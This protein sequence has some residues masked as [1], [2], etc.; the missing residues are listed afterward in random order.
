VP[1]PLTV[2]ADRGSAMTSKSVA[3]LLADLGVVKTHSRPPVS[4]DNPYSEAPF[5]TLRYRPG[6]PDRFGSREE[7]RCFCQEFFPWYHHEPHH[8]GLQL[9]TPATVP[10]G[11]AEELLSPRQSILDAADQAH[12]E[13]FV[14]RPPKHPSL[15]EAVWIHPPATNQSK[16]P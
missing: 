9:M 10:Y 3:L 14:Q 15:P 8:S 12:P 4:D 16:T 7:A 13:R 11:P 5:K 2:H 1:G 6:F